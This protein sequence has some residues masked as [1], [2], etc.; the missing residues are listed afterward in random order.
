MILLMDPKHL[1]K[2]IRNGI[3]SSG[4]QPYHKRNL[5][6]KGHSI[7]WIHWIQAYEWDR[8]HNNFPI[9]NKLTDDHLYLNQQ[10]K[11]RN[12]LAEQVLD[13]YIHHL[14][15]EYQKSLGD[16]G[17][18][19]NGS[20]ELLSNTSKLVANYKDKRAIVAITDQRLSE[21][22]NVYRWFK[23]WEE[24][25]E[26]NKDILPARKNNCLISWQTRDDLAS[27]VLGFQQLCE[28]HLSKPG[29]SVIPALVNNDIVENVFCQQRGICNGANTNPTYKLYKSGMSTVL[30][31]Q[32][33]KS[34]GRKSNAGMMTAEPFCFKAPN[35]LNPAKKMKLKT[36]NRL[37]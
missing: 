14:M 15:S 22:M 6:Y 9:H 18:F 10:S 8:N 4:T 34:R 35:P 3:L 27:Y 28:M 11:M 19:L 25:I 33:L 37:N 12:H 36:K 13:A 17:Q 32:S 20:I 5:K 24:D 26:G 29:Y 7:H 1:G 21:N 2:K 23:E 30:L 31:G 16:K